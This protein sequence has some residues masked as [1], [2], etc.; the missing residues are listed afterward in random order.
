MTNLPPN[1]LAQLQADTR[2]IV[3]EVERLTGLQS[4]WSGNVL[5]G[6]EVDSTGIPLYLGAKPWNCD[7]VLHQS[8]LLLVARYSRLIHEAFHSVS[9]GLNKLDYDVLDGFE[10][11]IVEQCTRLFRAAILA[12]AGL[13]APTDAR[14]SYRRQVAL[15]ETLRQRT[16]RAGADFYLALLN[17]PLRDREAR[18]LQWTQSAEPT[19]TRQQIEQETATLRAGLKP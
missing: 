1:V 6:T 2:A 19:K 7:I 12:N 4:N 15:L 11:G 3:T 14:T 16:N 9:V 10:E 13:P 5:L 8:R 17:I 18:I